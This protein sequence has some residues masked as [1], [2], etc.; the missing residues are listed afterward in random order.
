MA[1]HWQATID[2]VRNLKKPVP[3]KATEIHAAA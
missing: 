3:C 2:E 1:A